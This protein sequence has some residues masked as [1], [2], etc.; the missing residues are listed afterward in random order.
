MVPKAAVIGHPVSHSLSPRIFGYL[1]KKTRTPIDYLRVDVEPRKLRAFLESAREIYMGLNCTVPHKEKVA[2]HA[3]VRT[4]EVKAIGAAN[5]L[6][7]KGKKTHAHNTDV[8]GVIETL[9]THRIRVRGAR[10]VILGAGGA[11][12]AV[13]Y[14]VAELGARE[15][16]FVNR[17]A[18]RAT[19]AARRLGARFRRTR[20]RSLSARAFTQF[21][22]PVALYVQATPLGLPGLPSS[23]PLPA[24]ACTRAWALDL[25]PSA[26][27]TAFL[28]DAARR[29][30]KPVGGLDMLVWQAIATWKIWF[31][32]LGNRSTEI[33]LAKGLLRELKRGS[34]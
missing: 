12:L 15:V 2:H 34:A 22:E 32:G 10:V 24:S 23:P 20:F 31:G 27:P 16:C 26:K 3:N 18:A 1:A 28:R 7:F 9:K 30:L 6:H 4:P 5:V 14:A 29:G 17:T 21:A 25:I 19:K 13:G 8:E 33:R 11:A